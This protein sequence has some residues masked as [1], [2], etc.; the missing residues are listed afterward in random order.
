MPTYKITYVTNSDYCRINPS[1]KDCQRDITIE[2][3]SKSQAV[4]ELH[5][6]MVPE[7]DTKGHSRN[8]VPIVWEIKELV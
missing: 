2:A 6:D 5:R 4:T 3:P 1:H 7:T 8:I